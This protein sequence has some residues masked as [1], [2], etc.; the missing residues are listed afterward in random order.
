LPSV[1][2]YLLCE[3]SGDEINEMANCKQTGLLSNACGKASTLPEDEEHSVIWLCDITL[4]L[5][6]LLRGHEAYLAEIEQR[7]NCLLVL[8]SET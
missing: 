6:N 7:L 8:V 3:G 4:G 2:L 1:D 5:I